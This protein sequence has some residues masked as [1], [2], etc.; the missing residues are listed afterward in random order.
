[1]ASESLLSK[2]MGAVNSTIHSEKAAQLVSAAPLRL[3]TTYKVGIEGA[4]KEA[5]DN[6]EVTYEL[7]LTK[8][9]HHRKTMLRKKVL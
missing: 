7:S 5:T 6:K 9:T 3:M 2:A 4:T 1:M 8:L